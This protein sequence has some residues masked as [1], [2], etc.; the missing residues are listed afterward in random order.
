MRVL[1]RRKNLQNLSMSS[2]EATHIREQFE[3]LAG[4]FSEFSSN[5][6]VVRIKFDQVYMTMVDCEVVNALSECKY[7][8]KCNICD[9]SS[10]GRVG[11]ALGKEGDFSC[12]LSTLHAW[13]RSLEWMLHLS[14]K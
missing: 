2:S 13:I 5:G 9:S 10:Q 7:S 14:Y 12:G 4:S 8:L 11:Q 6:K 3:D 1:W